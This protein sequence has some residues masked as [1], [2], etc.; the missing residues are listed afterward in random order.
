MPT[1]NTANLRKTTSSETPMRV[2]WGRQSRSNTQVT[3][4]Q[5]GP[6]LRERREAMGVTLAE[7]EVATRIRQ[8][9]LAALESD[10]WNLLPGRLS[11]AVFCATTRPTWASNRPK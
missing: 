5:I 4:P 6:I 11:A 8:K 2:E 9:Y 7:A 3:G 1:A 10:E